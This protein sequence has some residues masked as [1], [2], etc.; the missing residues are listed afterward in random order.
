MT[1][2][3]ETLPAKA[4]FNP[5]MQPYL[6]LSVA[7]VLSV[8]VIGIPVAIIWCLGLGQWWARRYFDSLQCELDAQM[9]RVS[10]SIVGPVEQRIALEKIRDI[11]VV[12]GPV[13]RLFKLNLLRCELT[14]R[15]PRNPHL[16]HWVGIM[17]IVDA[18]AFRDRILQARDVLREQGAQGV[19]PAVSASAREDALLA[20]LQGIQRSV[21]EILA[22]LKA[23]K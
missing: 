21:D 15:H 1:V 16:K 4:V 10:K 3:Y 6:V 5:R 18:H 23:P 9:L 14:D 17:G 13:L 7:L 8:T 20:A 11:T 12:G 19:V 22:V 2:S